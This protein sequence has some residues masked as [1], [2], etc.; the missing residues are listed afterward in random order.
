MRKSKKSKTIK[1]RNK[2][3]VYTYEAKRFIKQTRKLIMENRKKNKTSK[4]K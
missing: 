3:C 4:N 2:K 1:K